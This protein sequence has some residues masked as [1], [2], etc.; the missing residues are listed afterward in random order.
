MS[1]KGMNRRQF[2]H[3]SSMAAAGAAAVASGTMLMASDGAW[4]MELSAIDAHEGL[5]LLRMARQLYPHDTLADMYYAQV[6]A[7]LDAGAREDAALAALLKEGVAELDAAYGVNFTDLS[8]GYQ[9]KA[10]LP[11]ESSAFFQKVR[12]TVVVSLYNNP[13]VWRHFGYEGPSFDFGG[14]LDRGFDDITWVGTPPPE[15]SPTRTG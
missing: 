11:M 12:G 9:L 2:L 4:A 13:L 8:E 15:A 5:T 3:T 10:L 7:D 6:V 1:K 14:Y